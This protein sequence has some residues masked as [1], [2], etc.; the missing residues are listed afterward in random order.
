MKILIKYFL[1]CFILVLSIASTQVISPDI[2]DQ[3]MQLQSQTSNSQAIPPLNQDIQYDPEVDRLSSQREID[4]EEKLI[5]ISSISRGDLYLES[6]GYDIFQSTQDVFAPAVDIPVPDEYIIGIGDSVLVQIFGSVNRQ[7]DLIVSRD[8]IINFPEIGPIVV[9]GMSYS[10]MR[11]MLESRIEESIIGVESSITLGQIRSIRVFVLGDV[12]IPGSYT[13]SGLSTMTNA[14]F[15]SGGVTQS[16]SLR[17]IQLKR[18]GEIITELDLYDL[19]LNGDTSNDSRLLPGDVIFIPPLE[20]T[21]ALDGA[22]R[23]PGIYEFSDNDSIEE[24][25][26]LVGG[27]KPDADLSSI[28]LERIVPGYGA[29][30]TDIDMNIELQANKMISNGDIIFVPINPEQLTGVVSLVGSAKKAGAYQWKEDMVFSDIIQNYDALLPNSDMHYALIRRPTSTSSIIE[31]LSFSPELAW[32]EPESKNNIK[33]MKGDTVYL[34]SI[35]DLPSS[36]L[37]ALDEL[38]FNIYLN[39]PLYSPYLQAPSNHPIFFELLEDSFGDSI[40]LDQSSVLNQPFLNQTDVDDPYSFFANFS[41]NLQNIETMNQDISS[42]QEDDAN[43]IFESEVPIMVDNNILDQEI[44]NSSRRVVSLALIE[45]LKKNNIYNTSSNSVSILGSVKKPGDYPYVESMHVSD[46]LRA[47][48]G[49]TEDSYL[50]NSEIVRT[51]LNENGNVQTELIVVSLHSVLNDSNDVNNIL[52]HPGDSMTIKSVLKSE[53]VGFVQISGEVTFPGTYAISSGDDLSAVIER[54]GGL[55][56]IADINSSVFLRDSLKEREAMQMELL[57]DQLEIQLA[58]LAMN[59][60]LSS[61]ASITMVQDISNRIRSTEP[62]GRLVI[63]LADILNGNSEDVRL[64]DGDILMISAINQEVTVLG[65]VFYPTSHLFDN[66][67]SLS[68]YIQISGGFNSMADDK[69][70]YIVRS[71]GSVI[72][73]SD[74]NLFNR[75]SSMSIEPGDTI[76]VPM[77]ISGVPSLTLWTQATQILYNT[78]IAVTAINSM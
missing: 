1:F 24:V 44:L 34:F 6:F 7:Y 39:P 13:V 47:G 40:L 9:S 18:S 30:I 31:V 66:D 45:E 38:N 49:F 14:L 56:E 64:D 10:D 20:S 51:R 68:D 33:L 29:N 71:N 25:F 2:A 65:E 32:K 21:I 53:N 35:E 63:P 77:D 72:S 54:A 19:L 26:D 8:G 37:N 69:S 23:K 74:L 61:P 3:I 55:S 42:D 50:F 17:N 60:E 43:I 4:A 78:A 27:L 73:T 15:I 75:S 16:G 62:V 36:F 59:P 22:F 11:S 67:L 46:L 57:A 12:E 58:N 5:P 48:G 52:L 76:V 28:K 41:D 70:V